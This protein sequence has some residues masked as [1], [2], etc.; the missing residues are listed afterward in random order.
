MVRKPDVEGVYVQSQVKLWFIMYRPVLYIGTMIISL[1]V[2]VIF[3]C[4][5]VGGCWGDEKLSSES[6]WHLVLL[7]CPFQGHWRLSLCRH[8]WC[9]QIWTP[10]PPLHPPPLLLELE[11]AIGGGLFTSHRLSTC[12]RGRPSSPGRAREWS[13]SRSRLESHF[14]FYVLRIYVCLYWSW[15]HVVFPSP[16]R[17]GYIHKVSVHLVQKYFLHD[18]STDSI[19]YSKP[20]KR[21]Q[22]K[23]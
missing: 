16:V 6:I 21:N 3:Y 15:D 8:H 5:K 17:K 10:P 12:T 13:R 22:M 4:D 11:A 1:T 19:L 18:C 9:L 20:K 23:N 7:T 2:F 14:L